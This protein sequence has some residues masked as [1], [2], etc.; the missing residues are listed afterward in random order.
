LYREE[1]SCGFHSIFPVAFSSLLSAG[2]RLPF[3]DWS[4]TIKYKYGFDTEIKQL[5]YPTKEAHDMRVP[6]RIALFVSYRFQELVNPN[7]RV[8][9]ESPFIECFKFDRA[10][11]GLHDRP[12]A[13]DTHRESN[14]RILNYKF[15]LKRDDMVNFHVQSA[16]SL[17]RNRTSRESTC[18][19]GINDV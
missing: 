8:D 2:N 12:E 19:V 7:R 11:A 4:A 17:G 9:G 13:G 16:G 14:H 1:L 15:V 6:E 18:P 5:A 3:H 10:S